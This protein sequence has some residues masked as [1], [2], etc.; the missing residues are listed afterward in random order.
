MKA[1]I[2][3]GILLGIL[4]LLAFSPQ[5]GYAA[6]PWLDPTAT[7]TPTSVVP[8]PTFVPQPTAIPI[9]TMI[10]YSN[11]LAPAQAVAEQTQALWAVDSP[12]APIFYALAMGIVVF[13]FIAPLV[14][15]MLPASFGDD[16]RDNN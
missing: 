6:P 8:L 15:S 12:Y 16:E 3:G 9:T 11:G 4:L 1:W 10:T 5:A 2:L 13:G 14:G 7:P